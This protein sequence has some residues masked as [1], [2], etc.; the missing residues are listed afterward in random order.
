[1]SKELFRIVLPSG[2]TSKP[3]T[4]EQ[5]AFAFNAQK[6][7]ADSGI[8]LG[9][10][11]V[12]I[13]DFLEGRLDPLATEQQRN[14]ARSLGLDVPDDITRS[15]ISVLIGKAV[16][17]KNQQQATEAESNG[18]AEGT[19]GSPRR[20]DPQLY[21]RIR[22]EILT[23][24]RLSGE[25]PLSKATPEDIARYFNDVRNINMVVIY[26]ENNSFEMLMAAADSGDRDECQGA[27]LAFG[28]P[29][30]MPRTDLRDL[31]IAVMWGLDQ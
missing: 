29:D 18:D 5:I 12:K 22:E 14:F 24:M 1:M 8:Q 26:S 15:A 20:P 10:R 19:P 27:M 3:Y 31:L 13:G 16:A 30:G 23:E 2:D 6:I 21:D 25:I 28:L 4:R 7:P 9:D 17:E 11:L